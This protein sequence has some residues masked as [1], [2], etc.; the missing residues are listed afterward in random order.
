MF[1]VAL[2][3]TF[4]TTDASGGRHFDS[5]DIVWEN[6]GQA[7]AF[8]PAAIML[9]AAFLITL[10]IIVWSI[11]WLAKQGQSGENRHGPDPSGLRPGAT[12][13]TAVMKGIM[14]TL[15]FAVVKQ[16][17]AV[18]ILALA[19][20][21]GLACDGP[22]PTRTTSSTPTPATIP[23]VVAT[24]TVAPDPAVAPTPPAPTTLAPTPTPPEP[25]P[26]VAPTPEPETAAAGEQI[27]WKPCGA[28]ECGSVQVPADY[29]D[30]EAGSI[31]IAVNVHRATSP[32]KRIGYLLVESRWPGS[33]RSVIRLPR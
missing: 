14:P 9:L 6:A 3:I 10:A 13:G 31:R 22:A 16:L 21:A 7:F 23:A 24:P 5:D 30:P 18:S 28:L 25:T 29:R 1:L 17:F 19:V 11:V 2:V 33:E 27:D 20:I 26:A 4:G 15:D 8:L 12:G 32:E